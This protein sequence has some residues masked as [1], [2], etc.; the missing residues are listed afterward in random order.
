LCL[1]QK[2]IFFTNCFIQFYV[3]Q[4]SC[5]SPQYKSYTMFIRLIRNKIAFCFSSGKNSFRFKCWFGK[6]GKKYMKE[7]SN[8]KA[9]KVWKIKRELIVWWN[10]KRSLLSF[11]FC[12]LWF[13]FQTSFFF[14]HLRNEMK[15]RRKQKRTFIS[16]VYPK[17]DLRPPARLQF[18]QY[19][20]FKAPFSS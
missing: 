4:I 9:V 5:L 6:I 20:H 10:F 17:L 13:S 16:D 7:K 12:L 19:S 1:P 14:T 2:N 15:I 8:Q 18:M 3:E 11:S